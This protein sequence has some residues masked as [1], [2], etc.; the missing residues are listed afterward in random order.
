M[1]I[2]EL[3]TK[4]QTMI[5]AFKAMDPFTQKRYIVETHDILHGTL[6]ILDDMISIA[7]GQDVINLAKLREEFVIHLDSVTGV[8]PDVE[9]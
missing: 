6:A 7:E 9:P 3:I 8:A 4:V 2:P 1:R 5:Q